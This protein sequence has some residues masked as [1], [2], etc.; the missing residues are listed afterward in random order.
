MW[1]L[2]AFLPRFLMTKGHVNER[3]MLAQH[4]PTLLD[5]TRCDPLYTMSGDVAQCWHMSRERWNSSSNI[6]QCFFCSRDR[7]SVAFVFT[8]RA[9]H[10][11][12]C[13]CALHALTLRFKRRILGK[14]CPQMP[15]RHRF[16]ATLANTF[17]SFEYPWPTMH[18][19]HPIGSFVRLHSHSS[20]SRCLELSN[21]YLHI[22]TDRFVEWCAQEEQSFIRSEIL[23][24]L[25][26]HRVSPWRR[27]LTNGSDVKYAM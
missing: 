9:V 3:N 23:F 7:E 24:R 14:N 22:L 18:N 2:L 13:A 6:Y 17:R 26:Y 5:A 21:T 4:R 20:Y 25:Q 8:I 10:C 1:D 16:H 15:L 27:M 12:A 19:N 11:W